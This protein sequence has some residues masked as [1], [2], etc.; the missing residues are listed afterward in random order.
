[1]NTMGSQKSIQTEACRPSSVPRKNKISKFRRETNFTLKIKISCFLRNLT[2]NKK[3][4]SKLI[5]SKTTKKH[6]L[7][8]D[9]NRIKIVVYG[10][11]VHENNIMLNL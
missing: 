9:S 10:S 7:Y 2:D 1:M 5:P 4:R 6:D 8:L 11:D 3:T